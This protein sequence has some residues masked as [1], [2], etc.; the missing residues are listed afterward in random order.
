M[1]LD[2]SNWL[3]RQFYRGDSMKNIA[4]FLLAATLAAS[5]SAQTSNKIYAQ[6]LVDAAVAKHPELR[7]IA[8]HVTPPNSSDNIIIASNI[9]R[10][11]KLADADDMSVINTGKPLVEVTK[12]GDGLA[13]MLVLQDVAGHTVGALGTTL[14]YKAGDDKSLLKKQAETIRNELRQQ[15]PSL[16]KLFDPVK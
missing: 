11:G 5:A 2:I 16:A 12:A 1:A 14:A 6:E 9:G 10:I 3:Q 4:P 8:M 13:V 7:V 15:T